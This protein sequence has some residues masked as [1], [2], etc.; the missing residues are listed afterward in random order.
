MP[1]LD[2][3]PHFGLSSRPAVEV[4]A[5][6]SDRGM[7][8][9]LVRQAIAN[10][11]TLLVPAPARS[12]AEA[13][14]RYRRDYCTVAL[15][16]PRSIENRAL[17]CRRL[18]A[19]VGDLPL[20][21]TDWRAVAVQLTEQLPEGVARRACNTMAR[22]LGIA[23]V[24]WGW[25]A[26]PHRIPRAL[27]DT[28][29]KPSTRVLATGEIERFHVGLR[30]LESRHTSL[31]RRYRRLGSAIDAV[32]LIMAT[33]LR[34]SEVAAMEWAHV[35]PDGRWIYI[36]QSKTGPRH[37]VIGR[38]A[39]AIVDRQPR[40]SR[41]VFPGRKHHVTRR[42]L[43]A[44]VQDAARLGGID[45]CWTHCLRHSFATTALR[46]G[47]QSRLVADALGHSSEEQL[48]RYQHVA[49]DELRAAVD[50]VAR[51]VMEGSDV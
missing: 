17:D 45:H 49:A 25:L 8:Q 16:R 46:L 22:I 43:L 21:G 24:E 37:V 44:T 51:A 4:V 32:R 29:G 48:A 1:A 34:V 20:V 27:T 40:G 23:Q 13:I 39:N 9:E 6:V 11:S 31:D 14:E 36:A 30:A 33:G 35:D 2:L 28:K 42:T 5:S 12:F 26:T 41:W 15:L 18:L 3:T 47:I 50:R 10:L 7:P 19:L 38:V